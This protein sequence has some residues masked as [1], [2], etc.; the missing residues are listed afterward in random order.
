MCADSDPTPARQLQRSFT[1]STTHESTPSNR[2]R[3]ESA[4]A[5]LC[6]RPPRPSHTVPHPLCIPCRCR[7]TAHTF[8]R[9]L[10][11]ITYA[12]SVV[13]RHL[14]TNTNQQRDKDWQDATI[15]LTD[16]LAPT[17][18]TH[19]SASELCKKAGS[20]ADRRVQVL[21]GLQHSGCLM[22]CLPLRRVS[23]LPG[24]VGPSLRAFGGGFVCNW[25]AKRVRENV[26]TSFSRTE[27]AV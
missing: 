19:C 5:R 17:T 10:P 20:N 2:T 1:Q 12:I 24:H 25:C 18:V 15:N 13:A 26:T 16:P 8:H 23:H 11:S 9:S 14:I 21:G 7:W 3:H 22:R 27:L 4:R 6:H